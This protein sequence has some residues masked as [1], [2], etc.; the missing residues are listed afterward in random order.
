MGSLSKVKPDGSAEEWLSKRK[1]PFSV[2]AKADGV[3]GLIE[4]DPKTGKVRAYTRGNGSVGLSIGHLLQHVKIGKLEKGWAVRGEFLVPRA[5]FDEA[6]AHTN[7]NPR[8][9]VSGVVT[10]K[11]PDVAVLKEVRFA[12]H[13][14][15]NPPMPLSK[16]APILRKAGWDVVDRKAISKRPTEARL[17]SLLDDMRAKGWHDMD[18]LVIEDAKGARIA[19]KGTDDI[20]AAVVKAVEWNPSRHGLLKPIVRFQKSVKLAGA[21]ISKATGNNARFIVEQKI[22]PG[23]KVEII[24]SGEVI[25]K[26]IEVLKPSK[27]SGL[28]EDGT[29]EWKGADIALIE[30]K[31]ST[32]Q[33]GRVAARKLE[34]FLK[35]IG[36]EG[37][38]VTMLERLVAAGLSTIQALLSADAAT[39][40]AA[41]LGPKQAATALRQLQAKVS[42][43]SQAKVMAASGVF[44]HGWGTRLFTTLLNDV[45]WDKL[46]KLKPAAMLDKIAAIKGF[47]KKRAGQFVEAFPAYL[48]FL[49]E[50]GIK[51]ASPAKKD[52]KAPLAGKSFC[53]TGIRSGTVEAFIEAN[54]GTVSGSV[55]AKTTALIV[56]SKSTTSVKAEKAR[57]LQRP[58]WTLD[59]AKR[60]IKYKG[61]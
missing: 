44:P 54:G 8:N 10:A 27:E 15:V 21:S 61:N 26:I 7:P 32:Q 4:S 48:A 51:P 39:L 58:I 9:L 35:I 1:G 23:A 33:R 5:K 14:L 59:E 41:G 6:F 47:G 3:S 38:R 43:L 40:Q 24:R 2:S 12:V 46:H 49:K 25:P 20:A 36:V 29:F 45:P 28:P 19:F 57:G 42:G 31:A 56:G 60:N 50:T 17:K 53:F 37:L 16:A 55:S 30:K 52:G 13:E 18:G 11:T 34:S 22:G